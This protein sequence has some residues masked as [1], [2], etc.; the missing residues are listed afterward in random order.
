MG[1]RTISMDGVLSKQQVSYLIS[2]HA[3][4]SKSSIYLVPT[5]EHGFQ[6]ATCPNDEFLQEQY[7][8]KTHCMFDL[9]G[10]ACLSALHPWGRTSATNC[11]FARWYSFL[12]FG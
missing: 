4:Q 10:K 8:L 5:K 7:T 9:S 6:P 11:P 1:L 12:G 3:S 2:V